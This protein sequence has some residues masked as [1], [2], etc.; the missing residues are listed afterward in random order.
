MKLSYDEIRRHPAAFGGN[1]N[2][3]WGHIGGLLAQQLGYPIPPMTP[4]Y[5]QAL[6]EATQNAPYLYATVS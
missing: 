1:R 3:L 2:Q 5:E 4:R 6:V